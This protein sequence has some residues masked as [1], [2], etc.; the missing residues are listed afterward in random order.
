M[1]KSNLKAIDECLRVQQKFATFN[2]HP[3]V[4]H[5]VQHDYGLLTLCEIVHLKFPHKHFPKQFPLVVVEIGNILSTSIA[6]LDTCFAKTNSVNK[7]KLCFFC[8]S[9][10][11]AFACV[12]GRDKPGLRV[13]VLL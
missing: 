8:V 12:L 13:E 11:N 5:A 10:L 3:F 7:N 6:L 9:F 2:T 1:P 4:R